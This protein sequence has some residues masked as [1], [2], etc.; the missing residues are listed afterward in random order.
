MKKI[1]A[2]CLVVLVLVYGGECV[3]YSSQALSIWFER[4]IP[5]MFVSL[6]L[7]RLLYK[8]GILSSLCPTW[9]ARSFRLS[10]DGMAL[11]L[12]SMFLGFP[13]GSMLIDEAYANG[14]LDETSA[15]KLFLLCCFPAPGFVILSVG[16]TIFHQVSIGFTLYVAQ[17]LAMLLP[18]WIIPSSYTASISTTPSSHSFMQDL[19]QSIK[20]SGIALFMM[21][22]YLMMFMSI[23]GIVFSFFPSSISY[24]LRILSEFSS[25]LFLLQN[26]PL[27]YITSL[28]CSCGLL[29]FGGFCVHLQIYSMTHHIHVPYPRFL[30]F[31]I[32]QAMLSILFFC[33]LSYLF[34]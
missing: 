7:F 1:A 32:L 14:S 33:L 5:S 29:G 13:N 28:L 12:S 6:V 11:V 34:V 10:K 20:E 4:L 2:I 17:I 19:T 30:V 22:G 27:S 21:G 31:R 3:R 23:T 25:G 16:A 26:L 15:K 18:L 9:L 8:Q 24:P